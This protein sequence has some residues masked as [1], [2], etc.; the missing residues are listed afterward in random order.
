VSFDAGLV[1]FDKDGTLID[2]ESMW[3]RLAVTWVER[4]TADAGDES[5]RRDLYCALGYDAQ[6]QRTRP[7]SPL[8]IA[9]VQQLRTIAASVLYRYGTPWTDAE[10]RT[11]SAF[12]AH[13]DL[14]LADLIQPAGDAAGLLGRLQAAGVRVGV[15]TTDQRAETEETLCIMGIAHLVDHVVC[16]DDGLP[17]KPDPDTLLVTCEQLG[18]EPARTAVVGDTAADLLMAQRAGAGLGV[19]VLTGAGEREQLEAYADVVVGSIDEIV[20]ER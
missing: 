15:I 3:G 7:Q 6:R 13:A 18:V 14:P 19:A 2:L 12:A 5:L 17:W 20:V 10:D 1:V 4:L 8:A 16:G 9:T 11:R